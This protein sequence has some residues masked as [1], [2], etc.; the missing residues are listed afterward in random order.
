MDF[1]TYEGWPNCIRLSN[2]VIELIATTDVGPRIIHFGFAGGQ[3]LFK[4][5]NETRGLVDGEDW[6]NYGGH[7][8]WHAPESIPRTY[9]P[10]NTPVQFEGEKNFL[11]LIQPVET[12]TGIQ[13]EIEIALHP[14]EPR[15][16]VVHRLT[17]QNLWPVEL[18]PWA[19]SVM[20]AGGRCIVPQE[21]FRPHTEDL[22]PARPLVLWSYTDMADPRWTW[23]TKYVQLRQDPLNN[24]PQK[25]GVRNTP[26]WAAY[27]LGEDLFIKTFPFDPSARYADFGCNNE[28]FTN[29]VILEIESLG[30]LAG[31]PPGGSVVHVENWSLHKRAIDADEASIDA[32]LI[33]LIA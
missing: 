15:V 31:L 14:E 16:Q 6:R 1:V 30:P 10:D 28:I 8:L 33:P 11:K 17:N 2:R 29:E 24:K 23:G 32:N 5:F 18:A 13:K 20:A 21:P 19:L 3:N 9:F 4:V 12:T 27:Q 26:G 25:I 7:R 22:L